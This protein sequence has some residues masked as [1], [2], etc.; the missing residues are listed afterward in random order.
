M[1]SIIIGS[2]P[3]IIC[4]KGGLLDITTKVGLP[5]VPLVY[6]L[7]AYVYFHFFNMSFTSRR[8]RLLLAMREQQNSFS[9]K[10]AQ[11]LYDGSEM[12]GA[13]LDRL[14]KLGQIRQKDGRFFSTKFNF[15]SAIAS[16]LFAQSRIFG[17][18]WAAVIR[19]KNYKS[20]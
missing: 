6:F 19:W 1:L 10:Q 5:I 14:Q 9:I 7:T 3:F 12:V 8:I 18:P 11:S 20:K 13:R 2:L 17:A 4:I 16:V 15:F